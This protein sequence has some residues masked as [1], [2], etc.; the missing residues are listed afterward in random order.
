MFGTIT[1][2][3]PSYTYDIREIRLN[4]T[5]LKTL[6]RGIKTSVYL[7]P[8]VSPD[9]H[10]IAWWVLPPGQKKWLLQVA[11]RDSGKITTLLDT[12]QANWPE[13]PTGL[14]QNLTWSPDGTRLAFSAAVDAPNKSYIWLAEVKMGQ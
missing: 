12:G 6:A 13:L 3:N 11:E 2:F 5:G 7:R 14:V 9:G 4:G 8:A 10:Y 1:N